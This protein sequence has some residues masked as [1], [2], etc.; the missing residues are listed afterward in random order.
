M[1]RWGFLAG[2]AFLSIVFTPVGF[3][4]IYQGEW[5]DPEDHSLGRPQSSTLCPDGA[6]RDAVPG[7]RLDDLDLPC[8]WLRN[9]GLRAF[10]VA[11]R[12]SRSSQKRR[13]RR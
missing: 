1:V 5:V 10:G 7:A 2:P 3:A 8:T 11:L 13:E 12:H 6:G 9:A 4:D